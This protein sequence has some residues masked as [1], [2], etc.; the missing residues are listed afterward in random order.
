MQRTTRAKRAKTAFC[1]VV[2]VGVLVGCGSEDTSP[3]PGDIVVEA[4]PAEVSPD[5]EGRIVAFCGDCH[6]VPLPESFPRD[7]WHVEVR[8]GY[9]MYAKSGRTDLSPPPLSETL[10]Y[11][12][13]R[14][15]EE[16]VFPAS[17]DAPGDPP[18]AFSQENLFL[19]SAVGILPEIGHLRWANLG[20]DKPPVLI[21]CDM[22]YGH[23]VAID[24]RRERRAVPQLLAMLR[25]PCRVEVCDLDDDGQ[26]DLVIADLGSF[27]PAEHDRGR[28]VWL[29]SD[30]R[31]GYQITELAD[32]LGRVADVRVADFDGDDR[33]DLLVA[34]FGW[35]R[36]GTILWLRNVSVE[37][38]GL[39]FETTLIDDRPGAIHLPVHDFNG[40]GQV[41]F[42]ALMSQ[43]HE[44]VDLFLGAGRGKFFRQTV[45][46]APD[47]TFGST[48][49]ELV[50]LDGDKDLDILYSNGD[51][52]DNN[53]VSPWHGAQWLENV[54]GSKFRY[55]RLADMLGA[56]RALAADFDGDGDQDILAVSFLPRKVQ[57][58]RLRNADTPSL[59]LLEQSSPGQ[60][61]RHTL[62]RG[63]PYYA[64]L[65][66]ADFDG[67]GD[68][69]F[70][71]GSGPTVAEDRH[72]KHYLTVW[73]NEK[74]RD[75]KAP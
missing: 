4:K 47:L 75:T 64:T 5:M 7:R 28:V 63:S 72:D 50:D 38:A 13:S 48:G 54:D 41:D 26:T 25:N 22:R 29:R 27:Q 73:W 16:L 51:A 10:A 45:W 14:A 39:R 46:A 21:A 6:A 18:V 62:E 1:L 53:F 67:D 37:G 49:I 17:E 74:N 11:F 61:R 12:R 9:E 68:W 31:G 32:G 65:E 70:V 42:A 40:D 2:A 57:P 3:G 8:K 33:T 69:D 52:F 30:G 20:A 55:H 36:T 23:V 60:F 35:Q 24:L 66:V 43:E 15:P 19:E 71:V 59:V 56:Y 58:A 34:E 44:S